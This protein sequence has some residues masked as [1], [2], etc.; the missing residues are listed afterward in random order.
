VHGQSTLRIRSY[1]MNMDISE[2]TVRIY[3]AQLYPPQPLMVT[4]AVRL[5][6]YRLLPGLDLHAV[7]SGGDSSER[8]V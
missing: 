1:G 6:P 4:R 3:L 8:P 7:D 5:L 2:Y